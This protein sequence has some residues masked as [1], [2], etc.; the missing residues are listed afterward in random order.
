MAIDGKLVSGVTLLIAVGSRDY[1][2][3]CRGAQAI[4]VR[5]GPSPGAPR[6]ARRRAA[7]GANYSITLI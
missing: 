6:A 1:R 3:S 2:E 7:S 5:R 4:S